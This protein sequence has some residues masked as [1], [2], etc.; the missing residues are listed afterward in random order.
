M[1]ET[2]AEKYLADL[3][4]NGVSSSA[5]NQIYGGIEKYA[6]IFI[7]G[8]NFSKEKYVTFSYV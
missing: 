6:R 1:P 2:D 3:A 8:L 7:P 5:W 4:S